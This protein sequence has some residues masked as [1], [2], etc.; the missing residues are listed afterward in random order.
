MVR[1]DL[2][3]MF[4]A[5]DKVPP[6]LEG[7][8]D[9]QHLLVVDLI[10]PFDGGQGLGEEGNWVPLFVFRGCLGEDRTCRKVGAVSFDAEGFGWVRRDEDWSGSDTSLQPSKCGALGFPSGA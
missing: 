5:F 8:D 6:L 4:R 1:P 3:L 7:S 9:C 2:A 10:V